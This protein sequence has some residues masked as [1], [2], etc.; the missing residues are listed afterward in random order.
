LVEPN[1]VGEGWVMA[2]ARGRGSL[3][4]SVLGHPARAIWWVR[5]ATTFI[6]PKEE[7][8]RVYSEFWGGTEGERPFDVPFPL[9][10]R[11]G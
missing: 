2:I 5:A 4:R 1:K 11:R 9:A 10:G 8:A 6:L 7:S 3:P